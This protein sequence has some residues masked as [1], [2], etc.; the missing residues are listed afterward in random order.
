MA[1]T[2]ARETGKSPVAVS[3]AERPRAH[4][5][6]EQRMTS[7]M[8]GW[9]ALFLSQVSSNASIIIPVLHLGNV[10]LKHLSKLSKTT[11]QFHKQ[12]KYGGHLELGHQKTSRQQ[13]HFAISG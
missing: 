5:G 7:G 10:N 1:H 12:L 13:G 2:A 8:T 9:L 3:P 6:E 4:N 11:P